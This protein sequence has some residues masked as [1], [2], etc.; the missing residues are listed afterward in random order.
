MALMSGLTIE[1]FTT[2]DAAANPILR[3]EEPP[4]TRSEMRQPEME[5]AVMGLRP[6]F[7][8]QKLQLEEI[9]NAERYQPHGMCSFG[10]VLWTL[11][12]GWW[13]AL[14][15]VVTGI[16]FLLTVYGFQHGLYCFRMASFIVYPFGRYACRAAAPRGPENAC[17][18]IL[19]V[20]FVPFYALPALLGAFVSWELTYFIPMSKFLW[21]AV[22]LT[23]QA[24]TE[25]EIMKL[26]NMNPRR[27]PLLLTWSSGSRIYFSF[28]IMAF[29]VIYLN[30]IPFAF[31]ALI[32]GFAVKGDKGFADPM[33]GSIMSLLGAVPCAYLIGIAVDELS[34]Q[35]GIVL[36]AILNSIFITLVE[37][38]L[39]YF[40]LQKGLSNVVRSAVTGAFL[41]NLLIIPGVG[42]LAAGIK[43]SEVV[44]NKRSQSISGTF[45]LLGIIGVLFPS[46]LYHAH[47]ST[48][49]Q[50]EECTIGENI[51]N[52]TEYIKNQPLN[53][54]MCTSR[55]FEDYYNDPFCNK[56]AGKL[57]AI[58][59]GLLP[60]VYIIGM[61]FSLKT[62]KHIYENPDHEHEGG[63]VTLNKWVAIVI[64][65]LSTV[66]FSIMAHVMTDKI[67]EVIESLGL[68][69]RFV[70][71]VF[72]TLVPNAAEYMNAIKFALNGNI[73]L[74]MEIGN[75]GAI[76][77]ALIE[78]P[79]L[80][81]LSYI[82]HKVSNTPMFTLIFPVTDIFCVFF[83]VF[84]RNSIL[85]EKIINWVT[86]TSFLII[87]LLISVV[88]YFE[89]F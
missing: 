70:G 9:E 77:S 40:S 76:L 43:W 60:V 78:M 19:W 23:F 32:A 65:L 73:G 25:I 35:L 5:T 39:Y 61:V 88:Y 85:T 34:H 66:M 15:Y 18:K 29:E 30:F 87:F 27:R 31:L 64:L 21:K 50:C 26:E 71:L 59:S 4:V 14:F 7:P 1:E 3:P 47:S 44:L 12:V 58:M 37:L 86:G 41:M 8:R 62:H 51:T 54:S 11:L 13:V 16:L 52:L 81:L 75:Q 48:N 42:M 72:Y 10:N 63:A 82:T 17:T 79:A 45:L 46:V 68:S 2:T 24:P 67:P 56:Y 89:F 84:L 20:I 6:Q 69:E 80:V 36:G 57:Q 55:E 22:K 28:S 74:S 49:M 33:F 38:I 83:A 53:C